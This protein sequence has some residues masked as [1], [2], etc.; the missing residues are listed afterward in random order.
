MGIRIVTDSTCDLPQET[1][2]AY[3]ITVIPLYINYGDHGFLDGV[4]ISR[5][6]FYESLPDSDPLPTT[7]TPGVNVFKD[8]YEELAKQG[9]SEIISIHISINLSA[10]VEIARKAADATKSVPVTVIDSQQLS[11]G[12]GFQVL[13]AA[14]AAMEGKTVDEIISILE[15]QISRT[16][17]IAA[18]D[19]L[20]FLR[21]SGRMSAA[22]ERVGSLLRIKPLLIMHN[23]NPTAERVRTRKGVIKRIIKFVSDLGSLD[24][25]ALVHTNAIEA[26]KDLYRQARHLF[27]DSGEPL[28]VDVT[29][30]LGANIGPGVVGFACIT[31]N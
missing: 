15:D 10:T 17:V 5:K 20:E 28:I 30:V 23:G 29:P 14:R 1:V 13:T 25:I 19:T 26:A 3:G 6:E 12:V 7:A 22:V 31:E 9:A 8:V 24:E 21:R 18:L 2:D 16:Y 27:P 4:D 11:L